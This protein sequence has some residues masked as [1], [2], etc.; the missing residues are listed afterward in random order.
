MSIILFICI[1]C[2]YHAKFGGGDYKRIDVDELLQFQYSL[3]LKGFLA[4]IIMSGHIISGLDITFLWPLKQAG[5]LAASVFFFLSGYGIMKSFSQKERYLDNF[6]LSHFIKILIPC[7]LAYIFQ[8]VFFKILFFVGIETKSSKSF[9]YFIN[10]FIYVILLC[11]VL[12]YICFKLFSPL[13]ATIIL[14]VLL[15]VLMFVGYVCRFER[16]FWGGALCFS[17]GLSVARSPSKYSEYISN[18]IIVVWWG[19]LAV[20]IISTI[21][22]LY[23]GEYS[24][25][26]DFLGRNISTICAIPIFLII[27]NAIRINNK[28]CEFLGGISYEIYII[29]LVYTRIAL[30][31]Q[32]S[33][34]YKEIFSILIL[35]FSILTAYLLHYISKK[36][37]TIVVYG[38]KR[39]LNVFN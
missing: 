2:L 22:F 38:T 11:Y 21:L 3:K 36:V 37:I 30:D 15:A 6:L 17:V 16:L 9:F 4:V 8:L 33:F 32:G 27:F 13:R 23:C 14:T 1:I 20:F 7:I 5:V 24:F 28:V 39:F 10:W 31:Q 19:S 35:S 18:N 12:F 25:L 34:L 26:G 29:H